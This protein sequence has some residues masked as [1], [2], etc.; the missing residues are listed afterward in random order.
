[1]QNTSKH[2]QGDAIHG[3]H[4]ARAQIEMA[5]LVVGGE[6]E[7][8]ERPILSV[9]SCPLA[10]LSFEGGSVEAQVELARAG[11]PIASLS[12]SLSGLS[13]HRLPLPVH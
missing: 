11:I 9:I 3:A 1:M 7:L 5:A 4:N 6:D 13:A 10:P 2:V 12:M 8:R